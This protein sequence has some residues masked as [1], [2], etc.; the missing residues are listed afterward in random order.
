[1]KQWKVLPLHDKKKSLLENEIRTTL[2]TIEWDLSDLSDALEEVNKHRDR[3]NIDDNEVNRRK[4]LIAEIRSKIQEILVELSH[5]NGTV[6]QKP[7]IDNKM[8]RKPRRS[9]RDV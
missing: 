4:R 1:M 2:K 7:S 5:P 3:F 8:T 9:E 6:S